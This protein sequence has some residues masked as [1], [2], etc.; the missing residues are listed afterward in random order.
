MPL[1][2]LATSCCYRWLLFFQCVRLAVVSWH[3]IRSSPYSLL[4]FQQSPTFFYLCDCSFL[5]ANCPA[6]YSFAIELH[7]I[8]PIYIIYDYA[9]ESKY[10]LVAHKRARIIIEENKEERYSRVPRLSD[11]SEM[12]ICKAQ[13]EI[14][15]RH[16][17][18]ISICGYVGGRQI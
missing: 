1:S 13:S 11:Q 14:E 8:E 17:P 10:R 16:L 3:S 18:V 6:G 7:Y 9:R 2:V 12:E 4:F 15:V 5:S